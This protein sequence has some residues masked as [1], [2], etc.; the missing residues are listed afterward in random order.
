[1]TE[2]Q[3]Q[4][5]IR[6]VAHQLG[7]KT[8]HAPDMKRADAGF[9]DLVIAGYGI[10]LLA[11]LKSS[12]GKVTAAQRAWLN[13]SGASARLWRPDDLAAIINELTELR[14]SGVNE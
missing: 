7:F 12:T 14:N 1:M 2:T 13:A 11:E 10:V 9:P 5:E 8:F 4:T 3:F 6:R